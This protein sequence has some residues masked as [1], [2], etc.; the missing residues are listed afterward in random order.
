MADNINTYYFDASGGGPTDPG[1]VWADDANAVDGSILT[2]AISS[3]PGSAS[4]N[5]LLIEG[6]NA[7]TSGS[8]I[9]QVRARLYGS[10]DSFVGD[11]TVSGPIYTNEKAELL[12]TPSAEYD[13]DD[14]GW[15]EYV[16]LSAP[17]GGWTWAKTQ[18]LEVYVF[19]T[20]A[21][22]FDG[23]IYRVEV[24]VTSGTSSGPLPMFFRP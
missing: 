16:T 24:E 23:S 2:N 10:G 7:P 18:A 3:T 11:T 14:D 17:S 20:A 8:G 4:S 13:L 6:T 21:D 19:A 12:G 22:L 15:S 1:G 9:S 5:Y